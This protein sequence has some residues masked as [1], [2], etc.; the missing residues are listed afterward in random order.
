MQYIR[1][2]WDLCVDKSN[3]NATTWKIALISKG[4]LGTLQYQR[5]CLRGNYTK[6]HLIKT[7][8]IQGKGVLS[9][10]LLHFLNVMGQIYK[11]KWHNE[12]IN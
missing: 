10:A 7:M 4:L 8:C 11:D 3:G 5:K 6:I 2:Q 9:P 1:I 12:L